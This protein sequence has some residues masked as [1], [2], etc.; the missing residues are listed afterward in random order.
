MSKPVRVSAASAVTLAL[1]LVAA[2]AAFTWPLLVRPSSSLGA[3]SGTQAPIVFALVLPLLLAVALTQLSG[4]GIDVKGLAMLG[5]LTAVGAALRPLGGGTAGLETVFFLLVLAGRVFGPGFG[6]LLGATTMFT[7]ALLTGGVG[8]WLPYQMLAA[9][10]VGLF[11]GLLPARVRGRAE[12]IM[13]G[14]Y[15]FVMGF[16]Y[17]ALMDLAFWPFGAGTDTSISY[18]AGAPVGENLRRFLAYNLATAMGWNLGRAL[19]NLVL[20]LLLGRGILL[21]LRRASRRAEFSPRGA[22]QVDG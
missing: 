16:G 3:Y 15:G 2:L 17:G 6:F 4:R 14:A 9:G 11:A 10:F 8:P 19:S 13:L 1:T 5:V 22:T 7:S 21:V 12:V 20:L 18:V